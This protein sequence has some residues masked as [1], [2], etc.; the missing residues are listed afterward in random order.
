MQSA[1]RTTSSQTKVVRYTTSFGK[2]AVMTDYDCLLPGESIR[3]L[4]TTL[5]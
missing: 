4:S 2:L 5:K 1:D 3:C